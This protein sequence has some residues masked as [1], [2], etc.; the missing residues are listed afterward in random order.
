M[1]WI[2][3]T[4]PYPTTITISFIPNVLQSFSYSLSW[5]LAVEAAKKG[6]NMQEK[7]QSAIAHVRL[8]LPNEL[9]TCAIRFITVSKWCG[10]AAHCAYTLS[11]H[12]MTDYS[13]H[14][15]FFSSPVRVSQ[16]DILCAK[17]R[18]EKMFHSA[19][20]VLR[21]NKKKRINCVSL[22]FVID[23]P[24]FISLSFFVYF[25]SPFDDFDVVVF[26]MSMRMIKGIIHIWMV[27]VCPHLVCWMSAAAQWM[28]I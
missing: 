10:I 3:V 1:K 11:I 5:T 12:L 23:I 16:K 20:H 7:T 4:P 15:L 24:H 9:I 26:L 25:H 28:P 8:T 22:S 18:G 2:D 21:L 19:S 27:F 13:I 17:K 14:A 6:K